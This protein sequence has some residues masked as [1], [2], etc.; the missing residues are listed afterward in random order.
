M[1]SLPVASQVYLTSEFLKASAMFFKRGQSLLNLFPKI[2]EWFLLGYDSNSRAYH[3]FNKDSSCVEIICDTMFDETN[4]SQKEQVDLDPVDDEEAPC[5]A[6]QRM[7][8]GDVRLQDP[9]DKLQGHSLNDTTPP[10][11]WFD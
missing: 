3:V 11:Q 9:S 7:A 4:D 1:C 10:A 5:D 8:I 6:L 2:Y